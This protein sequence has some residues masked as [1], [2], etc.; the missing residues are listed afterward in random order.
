MRT[1]LPLLIVSLALPAC[2]GPFATARREGTSDAYK[3]FVANYPDHHKAPKAAQRAEEMD[4]GAALK[5]DTASGYALFV[6]A[7]PTSDKVAEARQRGDERAW[8]EARQNGELAAYQGYVQ[9]YPE[10]GHVQDAE[11]AIEDLVVEEARYADS[12]E[13][14]GRYMFRYPEGRYIQEAREKR[15]ERGWEA[16]V[17]GNSKASYETYLRQHPN[18]EHRQE[19]RNW[20]SSLAI[21]TLQP[22]LVVGSTWRPTWAHRSDRA[23]LQRNLQEGLLNDI[24]SGVPLRSVLVEDAV[25]NEHPADRHGREPGVGLFVVEVSQDVGRTFEPSGHA[26]TL[27]TTVSVYVAA[28]DDPLWTWSFEA[29]T[30]ETIYGSTEESLYTEAVEEWGAILRGA[31]LPLEELV[32]PVIP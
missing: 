27:P 14:W 29:T 31:P 19:A 7:H 25:P 12:V 16:A 8:A 4:W 1:L 17:K 9:A 30:P 21:A 32:N 20:L 26:T 15:D 28:T 6:V 10:G 18:G 3:R 13:S 23:R 22:V 5:G 11:H 2:G 24:K